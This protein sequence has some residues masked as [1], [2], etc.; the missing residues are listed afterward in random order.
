[1]ELFCQFN[2]TEMKFLLIYSA[3]AAVAT[4]FAFKSNIA[5]EDVESLWYLQDLV[6]RLNNDIQ[7]FENFFVAVI[8]NAESADWSDLTEIQRAVA[9]GLL[10][11]FKRALK[12]CQNVKAELKKTGENKEAL[13]ILTTKGL[14][15]IDRL[16]GDIY[17]LVRIE[18]IDK[19]SK[20]GLE[21]AFY[22]VSRARN[23]IANVLREL[24]E[25]WT[26]N[27]I[28]INNYFYQIKR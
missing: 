6:K 5:S 7:K 13:I 12:D 4:S 15:Q 22:L 24:E 23:E 25:L 2:W 27:L 17:Q 8:K 19:K 9:E 26:I 11:L 28:K 10:K 18:R 21:V 1:M 3:L 14:D 20:E 16:M